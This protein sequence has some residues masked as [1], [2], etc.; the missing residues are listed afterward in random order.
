LQ[1]GP[2]IRKDRVNFADRG[3]VSNFDDEMFHG[4][5]VEA[6]DE[7]IK[8]PRQPGLELCH[9]CN[10]HRTLNA[11]HR[12]PKN[13]KWGLIPGL[14]PVWGQ[15]WEPPR[16]VSLGGRRKFGVGPRSAGLRPGA[17]SGYY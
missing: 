13:G 6:F 7:K 3:R 17:V 12:T 1:K 5:R 14:F 11:E 4:K 9:A 2:V 15:C 8:A 16:V 10:E